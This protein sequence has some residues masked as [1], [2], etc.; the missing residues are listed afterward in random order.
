[1]AILQFDFQINSASLSRIK[2][3]R[4]VFLDNVLSF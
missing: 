3:A 4:G 1:M 2:K